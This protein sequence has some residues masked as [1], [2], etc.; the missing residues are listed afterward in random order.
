[1]RDVHGA[2]NAAREAARMAERGG[3]SAVALRAWHEAVRLGDVHA[4]DQLV[5]LAADVDCVI[6]RIAAAHGSALAAGD[7]VALEAVS[8]ELA[9]AEMYAVAADAAAQAAQAFAIGQQPERERVARARA[10]ELAERC[11]A[12]TP[13]L[14]R[15]L[16]GAAPPSP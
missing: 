1:M 9:S 8:D 13:A 12:S 14:D 15:I 3:Q 2:I 7:G 4:A 5:R 16:G 11:G 6:G 10:I